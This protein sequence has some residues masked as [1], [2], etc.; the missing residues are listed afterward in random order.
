M[1]LAQ[2]VLS[3]LHLT[4]ARAAYILI[5]PPALYFSFQTPRGRYFA[6]VV[7]PNCGQDE[8]VQHHNQRA[9]AEQTFTGTVVSPNAVWSPWSPAVWPGSSEYKH[10]F[11]ILLA[12]YH[13]KLS[14]H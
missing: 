7:L 8:V 9:Q 11:S 10:G 3:S 1:K 13:H 5:L 2:I 14:F 4:A 12:M 6:P